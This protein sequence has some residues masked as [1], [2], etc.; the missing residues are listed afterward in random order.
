MEL[1]SCSLKDLRS[2]SFAEFLL[3]VIVNPPRGHNNQIL[4]VPMPHKNRYV[5]VTRK[6]TFTFFSP[7]N[8]LSLLCSTAANLTLKAALQ[9]KRSTFLRKKKNKSTNIPFGS[10]RK[11]INRVKS[12]KMQ[13]G[14][15]TLTLHT[16]CVRVVR[17]CVREKSPRTRAPLT[18]AT[19][20]YR[21]TYG[22]YQLSTYIYVK[23]TLKRSGERSR[24]VVVTQIF[25][26]NL[27]VTLFCLVF[28]R[29]V[30]IFCLF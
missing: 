12:K 11:I 17:L 13:S 6:T 18:P 28:Q 22:D 30:W 4:L 25:K 14:S 19:F 20:R 21:G 7:G 16:R 1:R 5:Q 2:F 15:K 10:K 26:L 8:K 29:Y 3:D 27:D 9:T 23:N 24:R